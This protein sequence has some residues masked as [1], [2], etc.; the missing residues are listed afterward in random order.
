[1]CLSFV[2]ILFA[3][4]IN[5]A[6]LDGVGLANTLFNIVVLSLSQGYSYV[7]DTFGPQVYGS[8]RPGE[9]TTCLIKCLLQGVILHLILLGPFL[10]LVYLIDMLP[11]SGVYPTLDAGGRSQ[12]CDYREIAV[13]YLRLTVPIE[14]L[15]Y[16]IILRGHP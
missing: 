7:F 8:S 1:M 16:A 11:N 12:N 6:H 10:N 14:F 4:N 9:L 2:T 3:G 5:K 15:D 13:A